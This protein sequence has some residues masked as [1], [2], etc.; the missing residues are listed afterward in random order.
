MRW[1]SLWECHHNSG[2]S[3]TAGISIL[4]N[5]FSLASV[6]AVV[7]VGNRVSIH[8]AIAKVTAIWLD[9]YESNQTLASWYNVFNAVSAVY[10]SAP[11][12]RISEEETHK[13]LF[14]STK[15]A[16][17]YSGL[18]Q[19]RRN[20]AREIRSAWFSMTGRKA[21]VRWPDMSSR[22]RRHETSPK[23]SSNDKN[24]CTLSLSSVSLKNS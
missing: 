9:V 23:Q 15:W 1:R 22:A 17:T 19:L 14:R 2:G 21:P 3:K 13:V 20:N 7:I 11:W 5:T 12:T 10:R 18:Y 16:G 6:A 4:F 24:A 8:A